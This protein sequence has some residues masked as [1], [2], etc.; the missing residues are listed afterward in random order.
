MVS[1]IYKHLY[2]T[3]DSWSKDQLVREENENINQ[4]NL[5]FEDIHFLSRM[6]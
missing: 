2:V 4:K 5:T 1:I 3:N 6:S